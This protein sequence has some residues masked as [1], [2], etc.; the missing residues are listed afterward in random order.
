MFLKHRFIDCC[1]LLSRLNM[2]TY[3]HENHKSRSASFVQY[4][5]KPYASKLNEL[6]G[7][8][9]GIC[10]TSWSTFFHNPVER[11]ASVEMH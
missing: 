8:P 2:N 3:H 11:D 5:Y 6:Q 1:A 10:S 4:L 9:L 7:T